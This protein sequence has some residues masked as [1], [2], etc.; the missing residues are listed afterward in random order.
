MA[1]TW[2]GEFPYENLLL[3]GYLGAA[4]VGSFPANGYGLSDMIGNVWEWTRDDWYPNNRKHSQSCCSKKPTEKTSHSNVRVQ[5]V[6]K[7]GSYLCAPNYCLRY[8][9]AARIGQ[10]IDSTTEHTGFRCVV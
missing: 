9:P 1:N 5:K 8:R 6:L 2:Q 7:G 10:E 4:P 3:D